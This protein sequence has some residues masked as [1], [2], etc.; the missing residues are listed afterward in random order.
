VSWLSLKNAS[1][2]VTARLECLSERGQRL[3]SVAAVI[4]R[5]FDFA[6]LQHAAGLSEREAAEGVEELVGRRVLHGLGQRFDFTHEW[7]REVAY[8]QLV[9]PRRNVLHVR[10]A[11]ALEAVYARNL[12]Q[13][14]ATVAEHYRAGEVWDKALAHSRLAGARAMQP[15]AYGEAVAC[16]E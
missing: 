5:E 2:A 16:F 15:S 11:K 4:G 9:Q 3:V 8:D 14:R 6:L 10:V 7:L 13:H 1:S 12:E